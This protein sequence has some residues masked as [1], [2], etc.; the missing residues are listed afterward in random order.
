MMP[1]SSFRASSCLEPLLRPIRKFENRVG[2]QPYK[3]VGC[4]QREQ[5]TRQP[6]GLASRCR[7]IGTI[8]LIQRTSVAGLLVMG[9]GSMYGGGRS[10][11]GH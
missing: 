10:G 2:T 3:G 9:A 5:K 6:R 11:I 4:D 8:A 1:A 7:C